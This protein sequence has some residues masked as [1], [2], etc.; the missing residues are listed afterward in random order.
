MPKDP[1]RVLRNTVFWGLILWLFGYVLGIVFYY[2][3]PKDLIGFAILP[4]GVT[5]T[6]WVLLK[7]IN[8]DEFGCYFG[9]GLIWTILAVL[10]DYFFIVK[11]LK[12]LEY[13]K[14]DVYIYYALTFILPLAVGWYKFKYL[15]K[16]QNPSA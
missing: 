10:L 8:R 4:F 2:A 14:L 5:L 12:P 15:P 3:V 9:L 11:M 16:P 7:K 13:Y 6:L 1:G